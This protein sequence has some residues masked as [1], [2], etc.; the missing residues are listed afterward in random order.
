VGGKWRGMEDDWREQRKW[1]ASGEE[2]KMIGGSSAS[3][4]QVERNGR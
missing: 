1:G 2:W 4:G 3:G